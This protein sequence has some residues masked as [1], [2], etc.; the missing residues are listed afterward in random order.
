MGTLDSVTTL[1]GTS[2]HVA[3]LLVYTDTGDPA[4]CIEQVQLGEL[5]DLPDLATAREVHQLL[6]Q[7]IRQAELRL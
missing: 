3:V 4:F 7:A 5:V 2:G 6:G 1:V